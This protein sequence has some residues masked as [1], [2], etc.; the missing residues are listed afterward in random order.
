MP[1]NGDAAESMWKYIA[2]ENSR[3]SHEVKR[4]GQL[5]CFATESR[6]KFEKKGKREAEKAKCSGRDARAGHLQ[7]D[8]PFVSTKQLMT[9]RP[10]LC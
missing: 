8:R 5:F 6:G 2:P 9:T 3:N 1:L 10:A 4:E 7:H